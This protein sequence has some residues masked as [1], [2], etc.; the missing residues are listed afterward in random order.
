MGW[1]L[2]HVGPALLISKVALGYSLLGGFPYLLG[3][4]EPKLPRVLV[5]I[6]TSPQRQRRSVGQH[7]HKR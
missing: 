3:G 4:F 1:Q 7:S 6:Y 5:E 2:A